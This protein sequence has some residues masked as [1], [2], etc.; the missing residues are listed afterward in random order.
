M[1]RIL[2]NLYNNKTINKKD[3]NAL[4]KVKITQYFSVSHWNSC[5]KTV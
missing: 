2:W 4:L 5:T 3:K 1:L